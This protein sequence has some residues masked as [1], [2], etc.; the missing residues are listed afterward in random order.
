MKPFWS[1]LGKLISSKTSQEEDFIKNVQLFT[2]LTRR[3]RL[4]VERLMH[5]REY[6]AG[7]YIFH[8]GQPGAAF[9][10]IRSGL[11][12]IVTPGEPPIL[13]AEVNP[14]EVIGELAILDETP[15]SASA[16]TA[17][18]ATTMAIFK[19]DFDAF[20]LSEP[21]IAAK[22]YRRLAIVIGNRLKATNAMLQKQAAKQPE[23]RPA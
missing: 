16:L 19:G 14:G 18:H 3:E 21:V 2:D 22:I 20:M 7:E 10:V 17:E 9:Y 1:D 11:V 6:Q 13:L 5:V 12:R 15:R 4:K 23:T 8:K